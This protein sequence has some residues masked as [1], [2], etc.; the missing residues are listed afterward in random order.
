MAV[1][2]FQELKGAIQ[3]FMKSSTRTFKLM[4]DV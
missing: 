1:K 4:K 3:W 2:V